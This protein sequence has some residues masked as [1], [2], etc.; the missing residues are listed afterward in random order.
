MAPQVR[1]QRTRAAPGRPHDEEV[2]SSHAS[3]LPAIRPGN[4]LFVCTFLLR[5]G[6][7]SAQVQRRL[8]TRLTAFGPA[9][10]PREW[11]DDRTISLGRI[12]VA[13]A[14]EG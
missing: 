2:G 5:E 6:Y 12:A 7:P 10:Y 1:P 14:R 13:W 8:Q 11:G 4:S 9:G 3:L